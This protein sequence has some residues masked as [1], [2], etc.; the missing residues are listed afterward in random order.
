F[1]G[2][3]VCAIGYRGAPP[4]KDIGGRGGVFEDLSA[5]P[6]VDVA[7]RSEG[8][9]LTDP[10]KYGTAGG[11]Q[12]ATPWAGVGET[13]RNRGGLANS[14]HGIAPSKQEKMLA[15][16]L[17]SAFTMF[18]LSAVALLVWVARSRIRRRRRTKRQVMPVCVTP[19][20][21][22]VPTRVQPQ[23]GRTQ[24]QVVSP[25]QLETAFA[26][27]AGTPARQQAPLPH[28][29]AEAS[30]QEAAAAVGGAETIP[31]AE[32][33]PAGE[34][35]PS[36]LVVSP[37]PQPGTASA[38]AVVTAVV[39]TAFT[40]SAGATALQQ[41]SPGVGGSSPPPLPR[42][43]AEVDAE[44]GA[45]AAVGAAA[46]AQSAEATPA[47]VIVPPRTH[48][49]K[50]EPQ[51]QSASQLNI[52]CTASAGATALQVTPPNTGRPS[53][54]LPADSSLAATSSPPPHSLGEISNQPS[55]A[56]AVGGT[57]TAPAAEAPA[58]GEAAPPPGLDSPRPQQPGGS[59]LEA[60][61]T[62]VVE[63]PLPPSAGAN[64]NLRHQVR[65]SQSPSAGSSADAAGS[66][67]VPPKGTSAPESGPTDPAVSS[68]RK[69][70]RGRTRTDGEAG[71]QGR[72]DD[73]GKE[74]VGSGHGD[75]MSPQLGTQAG[76]AS[77]SPSAD[78]SA[79]ADGSTTTPKGTVA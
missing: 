18:A 24:D 75:G 11:N 77:Q 33:P 3:P 19:H 51:A 49:G 22:I 27:S 16:G 41:V 28:A 29:A 52:A 56:A 40:P 65:T 1:F 21:R 26:P 58:A 17:P 68:P 43:T 5:P 20:I 6:P 10:G 46:T 9:A 34:A 30:G 7:P 47:V 57:V 50:H 72:G 2:H 39:P 37:R 44:E 74:P 4:T 61:L 12:R 54:L 69:P 67:V 31:S 38:Q 53:P 63:P 60:V 14:V 48:P 78:S 8:G 76:R 36:I 55:A 45:A 59:S 70:P 25:C 79:S 71:R 73:V 13:A 42:S 35:A 66:S 64:L 15:Q 23:T 62:T 32:A